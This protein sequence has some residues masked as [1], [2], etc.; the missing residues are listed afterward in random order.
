MQIVWKVVQSVETSRLVA[1]KSQR[2]E[3]HLDL[4]AFAF[5]ELE[6]ERTFIRV[7]QNAVA[8]D[9]RRGLARDHDHHWKVSF[10]SPYREVAHGLREERMPSLVAKGGKFVFKSPGAAQFEF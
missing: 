9:D 5:S 7:G 1:D 8:V 2:R 3:L 10:L 6:D 4:Q